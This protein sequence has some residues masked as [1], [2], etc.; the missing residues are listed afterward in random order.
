ERFA[1]W[2]VGEIGQRQWRDGKLVFPTEVEH[3][4]TGHQDFKMGAIG[5]QVR[6]SRC[7]CQYLLEVVEEQQQSLVL[8]RR[9][10]EVEQ[11]LLVGFVQSEH[12]GK[13]RDDQVRNANGSQRDEA[14]AVGTRVKQVSR[15][16]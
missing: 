10:Q 8:Q 1:L 16:L 4:T 13:R 9:F 7:R 3:R 12:L 2:Q 11:W 6:K 15:H 14:D 5:Q